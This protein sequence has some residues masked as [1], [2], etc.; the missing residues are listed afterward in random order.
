MQKTQLIDLVTYCLY[1]SYTFFALNDGVI[2][3]KN[4][5]ILKSSYAIMILKNRSIVYGIILNSN[6]KQLLADTDF[7]P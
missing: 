7:K 3:G 4:R 6:A 5:K 2:D 1:V